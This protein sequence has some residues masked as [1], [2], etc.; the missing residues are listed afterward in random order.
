MGWGWGSEDLFKDGVRKPGMRSA[1]KEANGRA[2]VWERRR[3]WRWGWG[4]PVW[5][6]RAGK[7]KEDETRWGLCG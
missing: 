3:E 7:S 1:G 6:G 4:V 2:W 5:D